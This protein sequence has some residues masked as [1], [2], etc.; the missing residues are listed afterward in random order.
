MT[1]NNHFVKVAVVGTG[2]PRLP[3]ETI[4]HRGYGFTDCSVELLWARGVGVCQITLVQ[5]REDNAR[6][7]VLDS[8]AI[9]D[10]NINN[11]FK[12]T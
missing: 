12:S 9:I 3:L 2:P 6:I 7:R 11:S 10:E 5:P 8:L 4:C 1:H